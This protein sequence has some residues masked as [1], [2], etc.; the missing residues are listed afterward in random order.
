M[1]RRRKVGNKLRLIRAEREKRVRR[2][3]DSGFALDVPRTSEIWRRHAGDCAQE[4][5]GGL[6]SRKRGGITVVRSNVGYVYK[7]C[8]EYGQAI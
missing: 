7:V 1:L 5:E 3:S 8:R 2:S 4:V 6:G